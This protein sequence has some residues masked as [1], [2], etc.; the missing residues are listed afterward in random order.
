MVTWKMKYSPYYTR[1]M[2]TRQ[3]EESKVTDNRAGSKLSEQDIIGDQQE[4]VNTYK[5]GICEF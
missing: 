4:R 3:N 1:V 2:R 5:T